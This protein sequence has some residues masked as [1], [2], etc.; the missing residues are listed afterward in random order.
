MS[1]QIKVK[2]QK[3]N[4]KPHA[5]KN[6]ILKEINRI[7]SKQVAA[8]GNYPQKVFVRKSLPD[9]K[10]EIK[11]TSSSKAFRSQ[12]SQTTIAGPN[13]YE[14]IIRY[15]SNRIVNAKPKREVGLQVSNAQTSPRG[16]DINSIVALASNCRAPVDHV[17]LNQTPIIKARLT[18]AKKLA[19]LDPTRAPPSYQRGVLPKY[20]RKMRE[21]DSD[22]PKVGEEEKPKVKRNSDT[23]GFS[24]KDTDEEERLQKTKQISQW[25]E[26]YKSMVSEL[27]MLSAL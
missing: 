14:G 21:E 13:D 26:S 12:A 4:N 23:V 27:T 8:Y 11:R 15:P 19:K 25:H 18:P 2:S 17:K 20:L 7:A 1:Q 22:K 9:V 10:Q 3:E 16:D 5:G 6:Q 24:V